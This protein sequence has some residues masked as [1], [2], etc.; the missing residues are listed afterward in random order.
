M[1]P[2]KRARPWLVW[3]LAAGALACSCSD[4]DVSLGEDR[5]PTPRPIPTPVPVPV[6]TPIPTPDPTPTPDPN[7]TPTPTPT[8][9]CDLRPDAM[10]LLPTEHCSGRFTDE[11]GYECGPGSIC[12]H[13][14]VGTTGPG[15][16]SSTD[17]TPG[18]VGGQ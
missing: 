4:H 3:S 10:C 6:P 5:H 13:R 14:T 17:P 1:Q 18:G 9:A 11:P 15:G 12:C 2:V 16:A 8:Y 7:P